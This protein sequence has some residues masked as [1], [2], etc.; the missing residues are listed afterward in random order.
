MNFDPWNAAFRFWSGCRLGIWG[1]LGLN[2]DQIGVGFISRIDGRFVER[3]DD[4][5]FDELRGRLALGRRRG[6]CGGRSET[7]EGDKE[8]AWQCTQLLGLPDMKSHEHHPC[9]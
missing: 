3:I 8:G 5:R 6:K 4:R 2:R 7:Q 1:K 9:R